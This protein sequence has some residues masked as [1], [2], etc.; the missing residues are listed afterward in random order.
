MSTI[1]A[2]VQQQKHFETAQ[3]GSHGFSCSRQVRPSTPR[4][5]WTSMGFGGPE[6][7]EGLN[8]HLEKHAPD[9]SNE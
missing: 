4:W 1:Q 9:F 8:S 3:G 5:L 6:V 7:K 2:W